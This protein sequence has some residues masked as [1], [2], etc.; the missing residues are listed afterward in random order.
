MPKGHGRIIGNTMRV[1]LYAQKAWAKMRKGGSGSMKIGTFI[2]RTLFL[3]MTVCLLAGFTVTYKGYEMYREA[4]LE[5]GLQ[6]RV[7][8]IRDKEGY[9][10]YE[11]LPQIYV[12]A[13]LSVED[14]RFYHHNGIDLIA[15]ARAAANDIRAGRFVEGGSTITQ[16]LAKNLYFDQDKE[17]ARKAAEVFMAFD[18]E[19][20]YTKDEIFELYVN[21]IYFGDGYYSVGDAS[22]GYFKKE[23]VEMTE[24]ESTLLAG[25]P[26]A[27]SRYAPSKNP[28]LAEKRQMKVL[29]RMEECGYFSAEE[30]ET[31]AEQMVA[32]R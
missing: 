9:T 24:Y 29:Q 8:A 7:E 21:C 26:N 27:P 30:A 18:I 13:V 6:D 17:I 20:N 28:A 10:E 1:Y 25:V 16:Q 3:L 11:N 5:T 23:P 4:L 2:R 19:K 22:E 12:N 15:I 32:I 31:V 14:H